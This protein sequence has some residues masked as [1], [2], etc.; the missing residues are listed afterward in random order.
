LEVKA[1]SSEVGDSGV[2]LGDLTFNSTSEGGEGLTSLSFGFTFNGE[3]GFKVLFNIVEDSEDSVNHIRVGNS[4][5]SFSNHGDDVEDLS[6]S[7]RDTL[8]SKGFERSDVG[9]QF[10]E[11]GGLDLEEFLFTT[12]ESVDNNLSGLV[13][14]ASDGIVLFNNGGENFLKES[15]FFVHG[16]EVSSS[17][18]EF[19]FS[20]GFLGSSV[21][22]DG[23]VNH[24]QS[25]VLGDNGFKGVGSSVITVEVGSA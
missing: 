16:G 11:S 25:L 15:I 9:G 1:L 24:S 7:V 4:G 2:Q 14:H 3:R 20:V 13:H 10:A 23:T 22:K 5:S 17:S 18:G 19:S 21:F 8:F 12:F 6:I